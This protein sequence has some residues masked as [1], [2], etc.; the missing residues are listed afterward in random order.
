MNNIKTSINNDVP[1][2]ESFANFK[3]RNNLNIKKPQ[4]VE[5]FPKKMTNPFIVKE[6]AL[7]H[8][9]SKIQIA[10]AKSK[11]SSRTTSSSGR[12]NTAVLSAKSASGDKA[13][14]LIPLDLAV[15]KSVRD[16]WDRQLVAWQRKN[17]GKKFKKE[18]FRVD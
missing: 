8:D 10:G 3:K 2:D 9:L 7:L 12:E 5:Y 4:A 1:G 18:V 13:P 6:T 14:P 15:F 16:E 11:W 17:V